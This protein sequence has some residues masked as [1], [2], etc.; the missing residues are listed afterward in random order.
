MRAHDNRF[1][2]LK[3]NL[4]QKSGRRMNRNFDDVEWRIRFTL[5]DCLKFLQMWQCALVMFNCH[6][7]FA[8][9]TDNSVLLDVIFSTDKVKTITDGSF[10]YH[11]VYTFLYHYAELHSRT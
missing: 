7:S 11:K 3:A 5:I 10:F 6:N 4:F 9:M 2:F 8:A 1:H